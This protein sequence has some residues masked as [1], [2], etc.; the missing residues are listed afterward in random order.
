[1]PAPDAPLVL[2][3]SQIDEYLSCP[4]RYR[5][6]YD[7]GIPT[8][9]HHALTYGTAIHHAVAAFHTAQAR[10]MTLSEAELIQELRAA[11]QPDGY[12]S[13]EHEDARFEAGAAA[14]RMFR[15]QQIAS[16]AKPPAGIER[17]FTF[18]LGR[19]E[20][21]GRIDRIDEE[22]D[23]VVI[24]DYK[25]SDVRDQK[26]A[27]AKARESLQLQVYALA[28]QIADR[29]SSQTGPAAFR[30][31][32]ARGQRPSLLT[33]AWQRRASSLKRRRNRSGSGSSSQSRRRS[34]AA[35]ARS[36]RSVTP[37]AA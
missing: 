2:S 30:R 3:F 8:P 7:I 9:A 37:S 31:V 14:L 26:R 10:G 12:L 6:R 33:K 4:E 21:R 34:L 24:T 27:D 35:T 22:T 23:G 15:T 29:H 13:R 20:I 11:W 19:D 18:R 17:P 36:E 25:S 5:L 32:G 16:G 1:M 28:H